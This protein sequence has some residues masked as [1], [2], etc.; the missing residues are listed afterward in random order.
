MTFSIVEETKNSRYCTTTVAISGTT[1][2]EIDLREW[3]L[4]GIYLPSNLTGT[5]GITLKDAAVMGGTPLTCYESDG[6]TAVSIA[7]VSGTS[8]GIKLDPRSISS[9]RFATLVFATT[10]TTNAKTIGLVMVRR[11]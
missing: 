9:A 10:Q 2:D 3:L 5:G 6:T 4:T 11:V 7:D 8:R 1:T